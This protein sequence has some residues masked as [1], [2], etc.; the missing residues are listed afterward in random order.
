MTGASRGIGKQIALAFGR[1]GARTGVHYHR[2]EKKAQEVASGIRQEGGEAIVL[3]ADVA[4]CSQAKTL[5]EKVVKEWGTLD[6]LVNNAGTSRDRIILKMSEDEW[7]GVI[8][9]NLNGAFWCLKAAA[10]EMSRRKSGAI[11]NIASYI[12]IRGGYGC[13][14]YAASKGGLLAL[15]KSAARELGK[16]NIRVNAVLPGFHPTDMGLAVWEK[17]QEEILGE[18][19][20]GRLSDIFELSDFIV[21]L[22]GYESVSGQVFHFDSRIS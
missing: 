2:E 8:D 6:V 19:A 3:G 1:S 12:G 4:D 10:S 16:F 21:R 13:A 9:T 5:V 18:H 7:R 20:L 11:I 22:A 17:N 15:T 14:N